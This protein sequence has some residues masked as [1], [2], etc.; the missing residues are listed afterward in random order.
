[1]ILSEEPPRGQDR[2]PSS[3][4]L[5]QVKSQDKLSASLRSIIFLFWQ[6]RKE[7]CVTVFTTETSMA[8]SWR[9]IYNKSH[10]TMWGHQNSLRLKVGIDIGS[11]TRENG[12]RVSTALKHAN[13]VT[14]QFASRYIRSQIQAQ[15]HQQM[16]P[17]MFSN[18]IS[19]NKQ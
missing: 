8:R 3:S 15:A 7:K 19:H 9:R 11:P 14:Q 6:K 5:G 2:Q 12:L 4:S 10:T 16:F 13:P 1:M 17:T 18:G